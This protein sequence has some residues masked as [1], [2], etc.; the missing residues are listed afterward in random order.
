MP[1]PVHT[2]RISS[3][4]ADEPIVTINFEHYEP[5]DRIKP[6]EE[7]WYAFLDILCY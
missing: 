5:A 1:Q 6:V 4:N 7:F 3:C 2:A